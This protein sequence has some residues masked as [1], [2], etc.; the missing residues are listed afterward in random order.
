MI[1]GSIQFIY[2]IKI[3][4]KINNLSKRNINLKTWSE[5]KSEVRIVTIELKNKNN[6]T[7]FVTKFLNWSGHYTRYLR[8]KNFSTVWIITC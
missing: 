7:N 5:K 2:F 6:T 1:C 4:R 8:Y 3:D